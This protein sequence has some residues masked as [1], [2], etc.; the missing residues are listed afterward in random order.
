VGSSVLRIARAQDAGGS[1]CGAVCQDVLSGEQFSVDARVVINAAGPFCDAVRRCAPPRCVRD[2]HDRSPLSARQAGGCFGVA[3]DHAQRGRSYHAAILLLVRARLP[4]LRMRQPCTLTRRVCSSEAHG[5]I[6]PKTK[7]GRVVF[8]LPWLGAAIAGTTDAPT[9]LSMA[10][11]ATSAEVDFI[12]DALSDYVAL[13][14]R[15]TDVLSAWSGIRPLAT[16]ASKGA[17]ENITRDHVLAA[18]S[19]L[20]TITGGKWT[21]YRRV[22]IPQPCWRCW[23]TAD[24][25]P[26]L[27]HRWRRMRWT[28]RCA[29]AGCSRRRRA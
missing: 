8:L 29:W 6:V 19:G 24:S 7:D 14:P 15:R 25:L 16:D 12:L 13:K 9:T 11:R 3:D 10:P 5:L 4:H 26:A 17:T 18:E 22:R 23:R 20:L 2:V 27:R 1:V 28:W 21:T